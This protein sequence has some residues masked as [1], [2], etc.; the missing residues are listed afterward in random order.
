MEDIVVAKFGGS[1]LSN[2]KQFKKVKN[3]VLSDEKRRYIVPSA[4]GR[5]YKEDKKITDL[6]YLCY[7]YAQKNIS[8]DD[9]FCAIKKRYINLV[10][11][12]NINMDIEKEL[13]IEQSNEF[14]N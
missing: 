3:I 4:P 8:F 14:F 9:V 1:S 13:S 11:E 12:L 10:K 6:L 7:E 2:S 5:R